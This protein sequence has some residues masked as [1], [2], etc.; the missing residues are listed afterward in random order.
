LT[1]FIYFVQYNQLFYFLDKEKT[2]MES[3]FRIWDIAFFPYFGI[4]IILA[5]FFAKKS[6]AQKK[7]VNSL[8][9]GLIILLWPL[10]FLILMVN[11]RKKDAKPQGQQKQTADSA[12]RKINRKDVFGECSACKGTRRIPASVY[13]PKLG[14][15]FEMVECPWCNHDD[16]IAS[17]LREYGIIIGL[18]SA[19][20][21]PTEEEK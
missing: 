8:D 17:R 11:L 2:N 18:V 1:N 14:D 15:D 21:K 4:G 19:E 10:S 9:L 7:E 13:A 16:R 6:D 5:Y 3:I 12:P 20:K